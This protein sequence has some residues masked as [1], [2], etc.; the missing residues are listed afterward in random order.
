MLG[1]MT[2]HLLLQTMA[3]GLGNLDFESGSSAEAVEAEVR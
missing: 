2:S 3:L 1:L